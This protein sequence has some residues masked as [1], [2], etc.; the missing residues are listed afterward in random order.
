MRC[1]EESLSDTEDDLC[2]GPGSA[3]PANPQVISS[4]IQWGFTRTI[5]LS[6]FALTLTG[7]NLKHLAFL[8]LP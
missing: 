7:N 5:R 1:R 6:V 2:K 3:E 4:H 8:P